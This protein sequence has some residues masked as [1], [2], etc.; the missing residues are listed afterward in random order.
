MVSTR[1]YLTKD[2]F[3][4]HQ[5]CPNRR[6]IGKVMFLAAVARPR[7]RACSTMLGK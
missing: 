7:V 6:F 1:Y 5:A 2:E 4:P 3:A